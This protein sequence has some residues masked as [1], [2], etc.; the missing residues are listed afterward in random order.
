LSQTPV[1]TDTLVNGV[2]TN[3]LTKTYTC[4]LNGNQLSE[5]YTIP[6]AGNDAQQTVAGAVPWMIL[7]WVSILTGRIAVSHGRYLCS[8]GHAPARWNPLRTTHTESANHP[9]N[10]QSPPSAY[11]W[12]F[13]KYWL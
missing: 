9:I 7:E 6:A 13:L 11:F 5:T 12:R 10:G 4:D 8:S 1:T 3:V 2:A